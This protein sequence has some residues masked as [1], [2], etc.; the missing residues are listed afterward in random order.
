[1]CIDGATFFL[2]YIPSPTEL[3]SAGRRFDSWNLLL[4]F[5]CYSFGIQEWI[6]VFLNTLRN[7]EGWMEVDLYIY[8]TSI[9]DRV[10]NQLHLPITLLSP[11]GA[12]VSFRREAV[13]LGLGRAS[14][15][16]YKPSP[17]IDFS[18]GANEISL[19]VIMNTQATVPLYY[20]KLQWNPAA[21]LTVW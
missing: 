6:M 14:L 1:M 20:S 19:C 13:C 16:S 3:F 15:L 18:C 21:I 2:S 8:L 4:T 11:K 9:L 10:N 5:L 7:E 12:A 17:W